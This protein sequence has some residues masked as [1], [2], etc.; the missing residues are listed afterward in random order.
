MAAGQREKRV[1]EERYRYFHTR[2]REERS[3]KGK[4]RQR[5]E[6]EH[7]HD[8]LEKASPP[9][10]KTE[11][12]R[13]GER[14][15]VI[16]SEVLSRFTFE[17]EGREQLQGRNTLKVTFRPV[18]AD[19][20]KRSALDRFI[21]RTAGILWLEE[22]TLTLLK[23]QMGLLGKVNFLGGIAGVVHQLD[24]TFERASTAEGVWYTRR[25]AWTVDYRVFLKRKVVQFEER[26]EQVE[27]VR[28]EVGGAESAN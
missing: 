18:S 12:G 11:R 27:C 5:S 21:N 7:V 28:P 20:P 22:S 9:T 4:L 6:E 25:G 8:P 26:R 14:D 23:V 10:E 19:L 24:M 3:T 17:V 1:F 2:V 16:D 15:I 13:Y